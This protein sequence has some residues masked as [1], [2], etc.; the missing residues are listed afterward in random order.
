MEGQDLGEFPVRE[1]VEVPQN[2]DL[3]VGIRKKGDS[4]PD[5]SLGSVAL[6]LQRRV[7]PGVGE[8]AKSVFQP[9]IK[10]LV[11]TDL[12]ASRPIAHLVTDDLVQPRFDRTARIESVESAE[13]AQNALLC[14]VL[15]RIRVAG[16]LKGE[17][18]RRA[19][20]FSGGLFPSGPVSPPRAENATV[21]SGRGIPLLIASSIVLAIPI[22]T[23][24]A[25]EY[26]R[27]SSSSLGGHE[28]EFFA[29]ERS[30][31]GRSGRVIKA[32]NSVLPSAKM[33]LDVI[34][35]DLRHL[36]SR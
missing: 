6:N 13:E 5:L 17:E 34:A 1:I 15:S 20:N 22:P 14:H 7:R 2:E 11:L 29:M 25:P 26:S 35:E 33:V 19:P 31:T 12:L 4:F 30:A 10:G 3:S 27:F 16:K 24:Q 21:R 23:H 28:P 9:T 36:L 8:F 18:V 32:L